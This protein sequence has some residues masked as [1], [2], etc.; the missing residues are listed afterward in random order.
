MNRKDGNTS[1]KTVKGLICFRTTSAVVGFENGRKYDKHLDDL[2][3]HGY[4]L[5]GYA[6]LNNRFNL[7]GRFDHYRTDKNNSLTDE[8]L[9]IFGL[10]YHPHENIRITPNIRIDTYNDPEFKSDVEGRLTVQFN[11]R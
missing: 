6:I 5:F 3:R 1:A 7:V 2:V 10:D 11:Y 8:R 4:S 9:F